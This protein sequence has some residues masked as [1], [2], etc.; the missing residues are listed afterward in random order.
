MTYQEQV[1]QDD[2]FLKIKAI[3]K[4]IKLDQK[5]LFN[6]FKEYIGL[7]N[8]GVFCNMHCLLCSSMEYWFQ[9]FDDIIK[10]FLAN[11]KIEY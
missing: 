9:D 4:N 1:L 6:D 2:F 8:W 11:K 5:K 3:L 10:D 7:Y